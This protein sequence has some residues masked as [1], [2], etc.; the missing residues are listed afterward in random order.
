M[1]KFLA[2]CAAVVFLAAPAFGMQVQKEIID[3]TLSITNA[4]G[5]ADINIADSKRVSFFVNLD[6]NRTTA[7]VTA[8][9][10][11]AY[12]L[13]GTNWT[14]I[15]WMD[16]AGGVTPQTSETTASAEQ[17]YVGWMDNR[18]IAK[19]LRIRVYSVELDK[20]YDSRF[21]A[22][23]NAALTVTVVQDK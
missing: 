2:V 5:E 21:V 23:D 17:V 11:A 12:S 7:A 18:N 3:E 20:N 10:T 16:V 14:D 22:A 9:V 13:N 15:S 19:Y 4:V 1:R 6:N 8:V